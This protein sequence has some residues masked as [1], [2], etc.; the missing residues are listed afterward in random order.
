VAAARDVERARG[1]KERIGLAV[2]LAG[3]EVEEDR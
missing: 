1:A 2:V 3:I